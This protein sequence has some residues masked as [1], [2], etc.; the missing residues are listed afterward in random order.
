MFSLIDPMSIGEKLSYDRDK[1][2]VAR[3]PVFGR[4]FPESPRCNPSSDVPDR[5]IAGSKRVKQSATVR[6]ERGRSFRNTRL[7]YQATSTTD[8]RPGPSGCRRGRGRGEQDGVTLDDGLFHL[9]WNSRR[10]GVLRHLRGREDPVLT[11]NVPSRWLQE[12]RHDGGAVE[13]R[14]T[15]VRRVVPVPLETSE[16]ASVIEYDEPQRVIETRTGV[17]RA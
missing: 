6:K 5:T 17:C 9:L 10:R 13:F 12:P 1:L 15:F 7:V 3:S 11:R 4:I 8:R 14:R 2:P 16:D